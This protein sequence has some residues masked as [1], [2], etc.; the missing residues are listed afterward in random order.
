MDS[1]Q[2]MKE[3]AIPWRHE[4]KYLISDMEAEVLKKRL[5]FLMPLDPHAGAKGG[6]F[7]RSLYFDDEKGSALEEKDAGVFYRKKYRIRIYDLSRGIISL[8][9][10]RKEG[11][12]IQ[13]ASA[14]LT[15]EEYRK[16]LHGDCRFLLERRER[17]CT[18][19]YADLI[20][21]R[22]HPVIIVDYD[23]V[24]FICEAGTV[25][26]TFD[27]HVRAAAPSE[28]IFDGNLPAYEV[29]DPGTQILEVKYTEYL[30]GEIRCL[31]QIGSSVQ[32][33]ASK[34]VLCLEKRRRMISAEQA[35]Y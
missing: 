26:I 5:S 3:P 29:L 34:Y 23:R 9:R 11:A 12:Y 8:E 4:M 30:P 10:K 13:K 21:L 1:F 35:V 6:Y 20:S 18:D 17:V 25:R 27:S 28:E 2:T 14:R 7:I 32:I 15:E 24:P 16:L 31:L 19:F 33:S 22:M